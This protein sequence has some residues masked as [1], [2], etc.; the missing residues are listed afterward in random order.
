MPADYLA[1]QQQLTTR[2]NNPA[3]SGTWIAIHSFGR[4]RKNY[5]GCQMHSAF[6]GYKKVSDECRRINKGIVFGLF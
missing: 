2:L 1:Q 5:G 3:D 6:H 4:F